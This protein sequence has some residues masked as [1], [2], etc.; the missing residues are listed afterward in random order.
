MNKCA[1]GHDYT[2]KRGLRKSPLPENQGFRGKPQT[3]L[4]QTPIEQCLKMV[5][6]APK[7]GSRDG[8][9]LFMMFIII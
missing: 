7:M 1:S 2:N 5:K 3:S 8:F 6:A 9:I 4:A